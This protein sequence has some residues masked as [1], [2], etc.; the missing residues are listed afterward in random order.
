MPLFQMN[1]VA[2][3]LIEKNF[4][5]VYTE[6]LFFGAP[7]SRNYFIILTYIQIVFLRYITRKGTHRSKDT[8]SLQP[9]LADSFSK[10]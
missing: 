5:F 6:F 7:I 1:L 10:T 3:M 8:F 9:E 2:G 4:T